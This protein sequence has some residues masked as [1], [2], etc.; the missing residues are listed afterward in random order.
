[1]GGHKHYVPLPNWI[2]AID[3]LPRSKVIVGFLGA[4]C[5]VSGFCTAIM[6]SGGH[7][8]LLI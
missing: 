4:S 7:F 6:S 2:K 8:T 3:K 1:M 5:V